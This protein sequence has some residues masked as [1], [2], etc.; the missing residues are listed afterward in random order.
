M[1]QIDEY[2]D[3]CKFK[4]FRRSNLTY[5]KNAWGATRTPQAF[6]VT[7]RLRKSD[8]AYRR[9]NLTTDFLPLAKIMVNVWDPKAVPFFT[10]TR[11]VNTFPVS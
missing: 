11:T 4:S 2:G 10:V 9:T 1:R 8:L 5:V 3:F 6:S 7:A